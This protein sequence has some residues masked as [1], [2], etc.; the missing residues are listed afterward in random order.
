MLKRDKLNA[1]HPEERSFASWQEYRVNAL[2]TRITQ[3]IAT[4]ASRIATKTKRW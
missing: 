2:T 4:R 3:R 1:R